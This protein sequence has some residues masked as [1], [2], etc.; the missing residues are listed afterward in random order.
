LVVA[1]L[2]AANMSYAPYGLGYSGVAL[3]TADGAI[4]AG[5]YAEN[6]AFNPSM[7]PMEAAV[8]QL[9]ICGGNLRSIL[10]AVLVEVQNAVSSQ[11]HS[12]TAVLSSI[13]G[14]PLEVCYA[15]A[16]SHA[17]RK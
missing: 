13:S 12:A 7:S 8:S 2:A 3:A 9:N 16:S 15:A 5:A 11:V 14:V 10:R 4:Y 17:K 6:A 1:A